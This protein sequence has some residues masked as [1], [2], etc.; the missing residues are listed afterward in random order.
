MRSFKVILLSFSDLSDE[1]MPWMRY[2]KVILL[3]FSDLSDRP[4]AI[5]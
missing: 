1:V 4:D 5:R 3:S 2:F